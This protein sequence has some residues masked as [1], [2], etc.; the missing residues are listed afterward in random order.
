M[1]DLAIYKEKGIKWE[2]II[3]KVKELAKNNIIFLYIRKVKQF[4]LNL[5]K[6]KIL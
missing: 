4:V 2:G 6:N 3:E 5:I 1:K